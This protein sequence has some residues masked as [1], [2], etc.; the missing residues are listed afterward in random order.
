M[1]PTLRDVLR[2]SLQD[3]G[4]VD[5]E[6]SHEPD[7]DRAHPVEAEPLGAFVADDVG[8]AGRHAGNIWRRRGV[9]R[10]SHATFRLPY[11]FGL[12]GK[13]FAGEL[14]GSGVAAMCE[15]GLIAAG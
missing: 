12:S 1:E 4:L 3:A 6:L 13:K 14:R 2:H 8:H 11:G 9:L 10:I 15:W 5:H 7:Q